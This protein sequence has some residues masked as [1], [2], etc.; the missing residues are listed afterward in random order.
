MQEATRY[1]RIYDAGTR[2]SAVPVERLCAA[3][4]SLTAE[5]VRA[6]RAQLLPFDVSTQY[7]RVRISNSAIRDRRGRE[8]LVQVGVSLT[9]MDAAL[10]PVS[11]SAAVATC[12]P[13][14]P[15]AAA[16]WWLS[17]FALR[18]LTS[19]PA[20]RERSTCGPW[21]GACPRAACTT[22]STTWRR[23][24]TTRWRDSSIQSARCASSAPRSP[25]SCERRSPRCAVRSSCRCAARAATQPSSATL[26][27]QIEELDRLA[28]LIDQILTLA[29]AESARS[30]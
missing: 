12:P 2:P 22:S 21:S 11:R 27:S 17:G 6:H 18:P 5:Q 16:S 24:S 4:S 1:L 9:T 10:Q 28:R 15:S 30:A 3:G 7:G 14:S 8:Y 19:W 23:H 20:R 25:T 26:A 13:R 29:R